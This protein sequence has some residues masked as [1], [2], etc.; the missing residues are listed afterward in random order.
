MGRREVKRSRR[1]AAARALA[2]R[3]RGKSPGQQQ[4]VG[5]VDTVAI[6]PGVAGEPH[7]LPARPGHLPGPG[8][9]TPL[10]DAPPGARRG[11]G[12][13]RPARLC[14]GWPR[15][16]RSP[17]PASSPPTPPAGR[18]APGPCRRRPPRPRPAGVLPRRARAGHGPR[19]GRPTT[20]TTGTDALT[21]AAASSPP[22]SGCRQQDDPGAR[23]GLSERRRAA[24]V[25]A[26]PRRLAPRAATLASTSGRLAGQARPVR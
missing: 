12:G 4:R 6:G 24:T 7:Q 10:V 15:A 13:R 26:G 3:R 23:Q 5:A 20:D 25:R 16:P 11:A 18:R 1:D 22:G 19:P 9:V 2:A 8:P 14:P 17:R 21:L